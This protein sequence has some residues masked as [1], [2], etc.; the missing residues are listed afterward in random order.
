MASALL[1]PGIEAAER[2]ALPA[3]AQGRAVY[4]Q[5]RPPSLESFPADRCRLTFSISSATKMDH[6]P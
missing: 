6:K 5:P 1:C 3:F 4:G 2:T